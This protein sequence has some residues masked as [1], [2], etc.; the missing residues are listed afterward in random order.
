[1]THT[2][3]GAYEPIPMPRA[4]VWWNFGSGVTNYSSQS[5][6]SMLSFGYGTDNVVTCP[7]D[8]AKL[9]NA[10]V[11]NNLLNSQSM[12]E[13]LTFIP[14][15][16]YQW[17]GLYGLGIHHLLGQTVDTLLGHDG[18][19]CN[20]SDVF[21]SSKCG[22]TLATMTNSETLWEGIYDPMYD[23]VRNYY[24]C[25]T[26]PVANFYANYLRTCTGS[27]IT[28]SD[29][30]TNWRPT[31]WHWSFPGGTLTGGTTVNDSMP[32]VI[33]NTPGTYAV[34][35]T[36]STLGGSDAITKNNYIT[37]S[38]NV[39]S[40]NASFSEGFETAT[41]PNSDW[42]VTNTAGLDWTVTSIGAATGS[43]SVYIDNF[44]NTAG[45]N[46]SLISTT[47]DISGFSVPKFSFK[48][49][50]Q[51]KVSTNTDKLQVFTSTDCGNTW[52]SRWARSGSALAT[53]TPTSP[54]PLYPSPS[55]FNTYT[56]NINPVAGSPNVRFK[57]EFFADAAAPGNYIFLDD[58][59]IF[60]AT[61]GIKTN[62]V[63]IGLEIYP[64][65]SL[66]S[67]QVTCTN[68]MDELKITNVLGQTV[69][70]TKPQA[71]N[72]TLQLDNAGVYFVTII[73]GKETS[74]KKVVVNK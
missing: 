3:Y 11:N 47:F 50:Y 1:M 33:Y 5:D 16:S 59:N 56:V 25:N 63:E 46:S 17:T 53:V 67:F 48:M 13:M 12:S 73:S 19:F 2:Y 22:F 21:H 14:Q 43:K 29:S 36:A 74:V 18:K 54:I 30:S 8:L 20:Q 35:Y 23:V 32:Q 61:I 44:S 52:V 26:V 64:N 9:V 38:S 39:P 72:T 51:Q 45:N 40:Y 68:N 28:F 62:Q 71:T 15:S 66:G 10:I 49:A 55:Q 37:I 7:T 65:P 42:S 27:T 4:G 41:L 58:I 57:F 70:E 60:D 34:S 6:T 24:Q 69:Y 31:A